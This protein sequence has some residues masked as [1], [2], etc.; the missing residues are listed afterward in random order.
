[1]IAGVPI[2][3]SIGIVSYL[4]GNRLGLAGGLN[5]MLAIGVGV[6]VCSVWNYKADKD[7]DNVK[8]A[9]NCSNINDIPA[10]VRAL[11]RD[12]DGAGGKYALIS[13]MGFFKYGVSLYCHGDVVLVNACTGPYPPWR[14]DVIMDNMELMRDVSQRC[15]ASRREKLAAALAVEG[16]GVDQ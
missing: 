1:M 4:V 9:V 10:H 11:L 16:T 15:A 8:W 6:V 12:G 3:L 14:E 2:S 13:V 5:S 7:C